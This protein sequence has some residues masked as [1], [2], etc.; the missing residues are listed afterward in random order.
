[1]RETDRRDQNGLQSEEMVMWGEEA[2]PGMLK[3]QC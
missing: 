2:L 3:Y 1:M